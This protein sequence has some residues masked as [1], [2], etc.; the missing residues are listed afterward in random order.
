MPDIDDMSLQEL[1]QQSETMGHLAEIIG[2]SALKRLI[3]EFGGGDIYIPMP[4]TVNRPARDREI[5]S[6][7]NGRNYREIADRYRLSV[8]QV[9]AIV[10]QQR[11]LGGKTGRRQEEMF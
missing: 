4:E 2:K 5:Y 7:F 1:I 3:M 11:S 6:L 10:N 9:Q 8:R